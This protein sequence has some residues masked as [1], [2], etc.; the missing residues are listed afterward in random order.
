MSVAFVILMPLGAFIVRGVKSERRIWIH[1]SCQL[2]AWIMM[3]AGLVLGIRLGKIIDRV[4]LNCQ[5]LPPYVVGFALLVN[6]KLRA[7]II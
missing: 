3:I 1:A 2:L 5:D 7:I 6:D 4:C